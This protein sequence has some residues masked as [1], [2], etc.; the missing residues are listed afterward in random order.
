MSINTVAVDYRNTLP[1]R[2]GLA[3]MVASGRLDMRLER[4]AA[5]TRG[6]AEGRY[7]LGLLPVA[8]ALQVPEAE[9][10]GHHGIVSDGFVGSV[11]I[12]AEVPL[13]EV[14]TLYL[15]HDS[16]SS[17]LLARVLLR[18]HWGLVPSLAPAP[19]GYRGRLRGTTAGVIIGDPAIEARSRYAYYY[20]LGAAW[21]EMT[22][23][24][25][26]YASW[27][28]AVPM[29]R[30]FVRDFDEAQARGVADRRRLAREL[31]PRVPAY[32]LTRYFTRQ[33]R[34][35]LDAR[36]REGRRL[37]LELGAELE[38]RERGRLAVAG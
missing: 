5:A 1:L 13:D 31:Q 24:P 8:A 3:A 33:L 9:F 30:G 19:R 26:V 35:D 2:A 20:D 22:G 37:F 38:G 27:L 6:F 11:G 14:E 17:V 21:R 16:R 7:V 32:D 4:P 18:H 10:V 28:S 25:F 15:D 29:G 36:A 12:F 34:F 23:L